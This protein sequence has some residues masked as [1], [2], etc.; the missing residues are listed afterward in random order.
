MNYP[1]WEIPI[2]GSQ[3][4]I[5]FIAIPHVFISHFAVGAGI[6]LPLTEKYL[7]KKNYTEGFG[8]LKKLTKFFL[9]LSLVFGALTG[10]AIWFV[11]GLASPETTSSLI[12]SFVFGW[13]IEWVFFLLEIV[14]LL[15]YFYGFDR[16]SQKNH[17]RVG[18]IYL[19]GAWLSLFIINGILTYMLTPGDWIT[20]HNFWSGFFN[21]GFFASLVLRTFAALMMVVFFTSFIASLQKNADERA[22]LFRYHFK[23]FVP[24][25]VGLLLSLLWYYFTIPNDN[26][27]LLTFLQEQSIVG[28]FDDV[29]R[30]FYLGMS[31]LGVAIILMLVLRFAPKIRFTPVLTLLILLMGL[32][33][34]ASFEFSREILRKPYT[35]SHYIYANSLRVSQIDEIK[36]DGLLPHLKW[37]PVKTLTQ[38]NEVEV[39]KHIFRHQCLAC[40]TKEP[41]GYRSIVDINANADRTFLG[42]QGLIEIMRSEDP[43]QN[44]YLAYM[45]PFIATNEEAQALAIYIA[46]L[47]DIPIEKEVSIDLF[48]EI[49]DP[50]HRSSLESGLQVFRTTCMACH[51]NQGKG[52]MDIIPLLQREQRDASDVAAFVTII[53]SDDP[54]M[55]PF[56]TVMPSF[57]FTETEARALTDYLQYV[58]NH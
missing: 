42:I 7:L 16:L 21:P 54:D 34:F 6:Y 55:N 44:P 31:A 40:H 22:F 52:A 36:R 50:Q 30:Y 5:A 46:S 19:V 20:N 51:T 12:H 58:V 57:T 25:I 24:V 43:K 10:V 49:S 18:Y 23:W 33:I 2:I 41:G 53:Q 27:Q 1:F 48:P 47:G 11:I 13:A 29:S 28:D 32:F 4:L 56:L 35:I 9:I 38:E 3:L 37:A 14:A 8:F 17:L 15:F 39:G 45:P 26:R